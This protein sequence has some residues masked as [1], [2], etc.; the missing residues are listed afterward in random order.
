MV[1]P[2]A[3]RMLIKM[4]TIK[5]AKA[6]RI[7]GKMGRYP[8]QDHPDPILVEGI[9]QKLKFLRFSETGSWRKITGQLIAPGGI[10]GI[11]HN[12]HK[13]YMGEVHPLHIFHEVM[14]QFHIGKELTL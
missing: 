11:F 12:G 14:G 1:S 9:Y 7:F 4:R 10:I 2:S 6:V 13:L 5:K 8:V 3:I